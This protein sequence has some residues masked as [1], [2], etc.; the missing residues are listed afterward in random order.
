MVHLEK[1]Q[2]LCCQSADRWQFLTVGQ[3]YDIF[4]DCATEGKPFSL[5][6]SDLTRLSRLVN[7]GHRV[8]KV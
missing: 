1:F 5:I 2:W 4:S 3:D 6:F 7:K 8:G